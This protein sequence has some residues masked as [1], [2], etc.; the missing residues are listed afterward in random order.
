MFFLST[1]IPNLA[2]SSDAL[3]KAT[4][5]SIDLAEAA[6]NYG[7]LKVIFGIFLVLVIIILVIFIYQ[8]VS[9]SKRVEEIARSHRRLE[10]YIEGQSNRTVGH[11]EANILIRRSMAHVGAAVK[12]AILR[13]KA[14]NHIDNREAV[15]IKVK[16]VVNNIWQE[17]AAFLNNFQY[18]ST[19][20]SSVL[21]TEDTSILV[22]LIT[23]AIYNEFTIA[24]IDYQVDLVVGGIKLNYLKHIISNDYNRN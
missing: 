20:L 4:K 18:E 17:L 8:I 23:E 10:A 21:V 24:Q 5:S 15:D 9:T 6:A 1:Q 16:R 3:E 14:E 11:Q 19:I 13:I 12:Y 22:N 2:E 7:A